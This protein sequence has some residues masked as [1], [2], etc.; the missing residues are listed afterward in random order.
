MDE[1]ITFNVSLPVEPWRRRQASGLEVIA[2][3]MNIRLGPVLVR[4]PERPRVHPRRF[5]AEMVVCGP[6]GL[7]LVDGEVCAHL[8]FGT[9]GVPSGHVRYLGEGYWTL[10]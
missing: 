6:C 9:C 10:Y 8:S 5:E 3:G 4:N 2:P 1:R 7:T